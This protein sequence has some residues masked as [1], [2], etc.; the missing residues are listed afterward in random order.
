MRTSS[1]LFGLDCSQLSQNVSHQH[2][3]AC[4]TTLS[5]TLHVHQAC[6]LGAVCHHRRHLAITGSSCA[7]VLKHVSCQKHVHHHFDLASVFIH[8]SSQ[9]PTQTPLSPYSYFQFWSITSLIMGLAAAVTAILLPIFQSQKLIKPIMHHL[10]CCFNR[11]LQ[12]ETSLASL[13]KN[14]AEM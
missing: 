1:I 6:K 11:Q 10:T 8:T 13:S 5:P 3:K 2:S 9:N 12:T 14:A 7:S 4:S